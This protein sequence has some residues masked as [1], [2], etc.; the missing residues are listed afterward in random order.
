MTPESV[1]GPLLAVTLVEKTSCEE[2]EKREGE[3][4]EHKLQLMHGL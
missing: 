4:E 1:G 2:K 3:M